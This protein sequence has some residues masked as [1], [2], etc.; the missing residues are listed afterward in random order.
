MSRASAVTANQG[1][2]PFG[3]SERGEVRV[4]LGLRHGEAGGEGA[5]A[6]WFAD[7]KPKVFAHA[8]N[9]FDDNRYHVY[10]PDGDFWA[11]NGWRSFTAWQATGQDANSTVDGVGRSLVI[12]GER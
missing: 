2:I 5:V 1:E 6:G 7:Y 9:L 11:P 10:A 3:R 8:G 4:G 12:P